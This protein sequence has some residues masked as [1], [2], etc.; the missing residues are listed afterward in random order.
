MVVKAE[1]SDLTSSWSRGL[2]SS[3]TTIFSV[4]EVNL[5]GDTMKVLK[6]NKLGMKAHLQLAAD[7]LKKIKGMH[8]LVEYHHKM[9]MKLFKSKKEQ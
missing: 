9:A 1:K 7:A 8:K 5:M 3:S 4:N 6:K 2:D